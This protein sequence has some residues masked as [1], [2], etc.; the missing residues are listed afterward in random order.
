MKIIDEELIDSFIAAGKTKDINLDRYVFEEESVYKKQ[1][2]TDFKT[3]YQNWSALI[4][5]KTLK[6]KLK[7]NTSSFL[8]NGKSKFTFIRKTN[9]HIH[10]AIDINLM[11]PII[12]HNSLPFI[13][14][15][16]FMDSSNEK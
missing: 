15:M 13:I 3:K 14:T 5:I 4:T 16:S 10:G 12:V 2:I 6:D 9:S 11:P 7:M 1:Q 8:T